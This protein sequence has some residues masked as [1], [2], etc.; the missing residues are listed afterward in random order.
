MGSTN[1]EKMRINFPPIR[2]ARDDVGSD[3]ISVF[4][5]LGRPCREMLGNQKSQRTVIMTCDNYPADGRKVERW[6]QRKVIRR[7]RGHTPAPRRINPIDSLSRSIASLFSPLPCSYLALK[8]V[9]FCC[10]PLSVR[11]GLEIRCRAHARDAAD[12]ACPIHLV[13]GRVRSA[14][15]IT[16]KRSQ[17]IA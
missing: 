11:K 4:F 13:S 6:K 3:S 7:V 10:Y 8:F 17:K 14:L 16:N 1:Y 15:F 12:A 2:T 5:F 9:C